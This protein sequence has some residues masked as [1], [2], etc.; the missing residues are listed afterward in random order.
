M[1]ALVEAGSPIARAQEPPAAPA[2]TAPLSPELAR[3]LVPNPAKAALLR[4]NPS[5]AVR[6]NAAVAGAS[7]LTVPEML[8]TSDTLIQTAQ[9]PIGPMPNYTCPAQFGNSH[10]VLV[11][12]YAG[13][14]VYRI[15]IGSNEIDVLPTGPETNPLDVAFDG[16]RLRILVASADLAGKLII[17]GALGKHV[18]TLAL[19]EAAG[20]GP[21]DG[22]AQGVTV[23]GEGNYWVALA[24]HGIPNGGVLVKVSGETMQPML[25]VADQGMNNPNGVITTSNGMSIIA[26]SDN[27]TAQRFDLAGRRTHVYH[28]VPSGYRGTVIDSEL[29]VCGFQDPGVMARI[30][31]RNG[32][33]V[34]FPCVPLANSVA[35]DG[36]GLVW[37]AGDA[38]VSISTRQGELLALETVGAFA[39][40][41]SIVEGAA[42]FV[43]YDSLLRAAL[44]AERRNV[45]PTI[46]MDSTP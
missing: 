37:V 36:N 42:H 32:R 33:S 38:G 27:G 19:T 6:L 1:L 18:K 24:Y 21:S 30:N 20:Q 46:L 8:A 17:V 10:A 41:L 2:T 11:A 3:Y 7:T 5:L 43:T 44:H 34:E 9:W 4:G 13:A 16:P 12:C 22:G 15:F 39:N 35:V 23:D 29:W 14:A 31:L 40:G 28:T 45:L 25:V 26:M